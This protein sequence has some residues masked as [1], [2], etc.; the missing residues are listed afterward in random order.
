[1][2][3]ADPASNSGAAGNLAS[4]SGN[5]LML[6]VVSALVMAP[7]ALAA[8]WYGGWAF[9]LFWGLAAVAVAWE[10]I[11]LVTGSGHRLVFVSGASALAVATL[12]G[13]RDHPAVAILLVGLGTLA[14]TIVAPRGR[15][16]W[17]AGG[18]LYAGVMLLAPLFLRGDPIYGF[19]AIAFLFAVV[20]ATDILAYFGG[21]TFGG[22]KLMPAVSPKKTWSGAVCGTLGAIVCGV[23]GAAWFGVR[24]LVGIVV[25][26]LVLSVAS[27]GGDLLESWIKRHFGAKDASHLIPGH[28]GVMDRLDGFW[29]AALVGCLIGLSRGG[30]DGAAR[31]LLVW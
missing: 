25:V 5:N 15:R 6:R 28:G 17:V 18:I 20:W 23:A 1:V 4:T 13:W 12:A 27:Q 24:D 11:A 29:A 10:W 26:A 16:C 22:P 21:R 19:G 8:A 14:G 30:F 7:L 31:G 3:G 9:A 2:P